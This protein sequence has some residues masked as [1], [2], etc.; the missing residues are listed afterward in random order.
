MWNVS[1]RRLLIF[2]AAVTSGLGLV[3]CESDVSGTDAIDSQLE[4]MEGL[5]SLSFPHSGNDAAHGP[6]LRGV[7]LLHSFE[8]ETSAEAFREAQEAD[9][10]FAL[11][12]WGE[13][14]T[15]NHPLWRQKDEE[16]AE[17]VL[18]R[19]APNAKERRAKA[20]AEREGMYLDAVEALYA[21][22]TKAE[23]D[24]AYMEAM[25]RLHDAYPDDQEAQ[26]FYALSILGSTNGSRDFATYMKASA[27]AQPVHDRNPSHPG[28]VHYMIHS[29]DDPV[30]APLGLP[31][32]RAYSQIAPMRPMPST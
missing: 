27:M 3:A 14:M 12:Y 15:Y 31:A 17:A 26:A 28:A 7:L 29:F 16:A 2:A 1:T 6:F 5:G 8:Y 20:G 9:P 21:E 25:R 32:A 23:Q 24:R 18:S 13:A 30:H 22:G 10:Q 4:S 11:A 19:L